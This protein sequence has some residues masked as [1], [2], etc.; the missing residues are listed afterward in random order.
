IRTPAPPRR[1]DAGVIPSTSLDFSYTRL[2]DPKPASY[3]ARLTVSP[4][5]SR[6]LKRATRW[7]WL[8]CLGETPTMR[9]NDRWRWDALNAAR[10]ASS[11][12]G[13]ARSGLASRYARAAST[14]RAVADASS[15]DRGLQ[16]RH[17]RYPARSASS[18]ESKNATFSRS[19]RRDAQLGLQ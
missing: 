6:D 5:R 13:T 9:L 19:G 12:N 3:V 15:A 7:A 18:G 2:L 1:N 8:Y 16:R 17:A 10:V 4:A 11:L 14:P